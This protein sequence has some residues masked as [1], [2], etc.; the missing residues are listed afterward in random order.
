MMKHNN[1]CYLLFALC[2]G[3]SCTTDDPIPGPTEAPS[4]CTPLPNGPP[5]GWFFSGT[6]EHLDRV[7]FDPLDPNK[8]LLTRGFRSTDTTDLLMYNISNNTLEPVFSGTLSSPPDLCV[9]GWIVMSIYQGGGDIWKIQ[10]DGTGLTQLT[11]T[12]LDFS[13][14]W[15]STCSTIGYYHVSN[16]GMTM[17]ANGVTQDTLAALAQLFSGTARTWAHPSMVIAAGP[18]GIYKWE[19]GD[20]LATELADVPAEVHGNPANGI[21]LLDDHQTVVWSHIWGLYSTNIITGV[22][23]R[24]IATCD[25]KYFG[26]LT[27]SPQ[28]QQIIAL[29]ETVVPESGT[30]LVY[31]TEVVRMGLDGSEIEVLDIPL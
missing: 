12:G 6:P 1:T 9:D 21:V 22:T 14:I 11:A 24:L 17:D 31:S 7:Q 2:I 28:L 25:S 27:Y 19:P 16:T 5:F 10:S 20:E 13:P 15:N 3:F 23:E 18:N 29:R 26:S 4:D 30:T 8:L